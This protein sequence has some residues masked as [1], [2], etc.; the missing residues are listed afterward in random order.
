MSQALELRCD[1]TMCHNPDCE[2]CYPLKILKKAS[3][4]TP[5][6]CDGSLTMC[7][8]CHAAQDLAKRLQFLAL[9]KERPRKPS[10][11]DSGYCGRCGD[12]LPECRC[13]TP[14]RDGLVKLVQ[15]HFSGD[16]KL[17]PLVKHVRGGLKIMDYYLNVL[18]AIHDVPSPKGIENEFVV[19]STKKT[20]K[21]IQVVNW[22]FNVAFKAAMENKKRKKR[23]TTS[24]HSART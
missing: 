10:R 5:C 13:E 12:S 3:A 1:K 14:D 9:R 23:V 21:E 7:P 24:R 18:R 15:D 2:D 11:L 19:R 17:K 16:K 4:E 8:G 20:D 6:T 22:V